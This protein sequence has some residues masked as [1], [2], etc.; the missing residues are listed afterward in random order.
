MQVILLEQIRRLGNLGDTV[1]VKA[2]FARNF[3]IP[4]GKALFASPENKAKFDA[5]RKAL[6]KQNADAVKAAQAV[7]K[8]ID[9]VV[10]SLERPASE[11]GMLYGS[12]KPRDIAAWLSDN[13]DA[14]VKL[15][16]V[17]IGEPIKEI[18]ESTVQVALHPEVMVELKV[19]VERQSNLD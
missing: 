7:E 16:Q 4:Q 9:G 2:G 13:T 10:V 6:E 1:A 8:K 14:K 12:V 15:N 19:Q 11:T 17:L 18:G 5:E 3:L